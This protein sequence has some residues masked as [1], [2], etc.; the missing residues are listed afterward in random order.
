MNYGEILK[1]AWQITWKH[2]ILWLFGILAGFGS[3]YGGGSPSGS[4]SGYQF[5]SSDV[6]NRFFFRHTNAHYLLARLQEVISN[7]PIWFWIAL[8]ISV[9]FLAIF[10]S[11]V[12]LFLGTLGSAGVIKGSLLAA[13]AEENVK[14]LNLKQVFNG[15]K[16]FYWRLVLVKL[17][18]IF[19]SIILGLVLAAMIIGPILMTFGLIIPCIFPF[20]LL[21]I[22]LAFFLQVLVINIDIALIDEDLSLVNALTR[23]WQVTTRNIWPMLLMSVILNLI[24]LMFAI[25]LIGPMLLMVIPII[26]GMLIGETVTIAVGATI[27]AFIFMILITVGLFFSGILKAF[28]IS[29]YTLTFRHLKDKAKTAVIEIKAEE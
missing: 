11:I 6:G 10:A 20:F 24:Q 4:G 28:E 21:L 2:K 5:S 23:A 16:P 18:V 14:P 29:A 9:F 1:K 12:S 17:A 25:V 7:T 8:A 19:G 26:I 27:S 13:D 3:T 22:P 15:L